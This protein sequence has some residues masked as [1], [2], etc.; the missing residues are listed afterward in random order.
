MWGFS[1]TVVETIAHHHAPSTL[2]PAK[3]LSALTIVHIAQA[4]V[5]LVDTT[6]PNLFADCD[7]MKRFDVRHLTDVHLIDRLDEF[8]QLAESS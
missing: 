4:T 6:P 5:H 8:C 7:T 1:N 3:E 2:G